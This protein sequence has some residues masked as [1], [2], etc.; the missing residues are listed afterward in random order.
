MVTVDSLIPNMLAHTR[1]LAAFG[2]KHAYGPRC[3]GPSGCEAVI[4]ELTEAIRRQVEPTDLCTDLHASPALSGQHTLLTPIEVQKALWH[5][6]TAGALD[7][8]NAVQVGLGSACKASRTCP[9]AL[10]CARATATE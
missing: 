10:H 2:A 8:C 9:V 3:Y 1:V 7:F 6:C 4:Y 5:F